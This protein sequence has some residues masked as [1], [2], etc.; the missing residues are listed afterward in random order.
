MGSYASSFKR[1][2]SSRSSELP[3]GW[4]GDLR[5]GSVRTGLFAISMRPREKKIPYFRS[6][7]IAE[8]LKSAV[9]PE[10]ACLIT[11]MTAP[12]TYLIRKGSLGIIVILLISYKLFREL[13]YQL[14]VM[15][16]KSVV[17]EPSTI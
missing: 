17:Y 13:L 5:S 8:V 2:K 10:E 6:L 15:S 16:G 4:D 14:R 12:P 7:L 11:E 1:I 3:V 9:P